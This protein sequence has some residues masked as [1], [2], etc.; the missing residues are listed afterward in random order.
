MLCVVWR[1][2][3]AD[4][5][6]CVRCLM[7]VVGRVCL[8]FVP[9]VLFVMCCL[10][11]VVWCKLCVV[12]CVVFVVCRVLS[13]GCDCCLFV[14]CVVLWFAVCFLVLVVGWLLSLFVVCGLSRIV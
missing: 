5:V 1:L 12:R 3:T 6:N 7:F 8:L 14:V 2:L 13:V 4:L 10:L 11:F 9:C